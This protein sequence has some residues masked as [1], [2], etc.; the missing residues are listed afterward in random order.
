MEAKNKTQLLEQFSQYLEAVELEPETEQT[1]LYSLFSE[2]AALRNEVKTESRQFKN[3]LG[4]FK[5]GFDS[6]QQSNN[7]LTKE[8][9]NY[10][11]QLETQK[12]QI[13]RNL[14]LEFLE[15]YDRLLAGAKMLDT[16]K[17][18]SS[19]F[20]HS[21]KQDKQ[22]IHSIQEGQNIS[23][24]RLEQLLGKYEVTAIEVLNKSLNPHSMTAIEIDHNPKVDD[25]I[26]TEEL[27]KGF[28]WQDEVLRLA[29][30]KVN[31]QELK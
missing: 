8:L 4:D 26:V 25:G 1:D 14:L 6:L 22:F 5:T 10:R 9:D 27:R 7:E 29:E 12:K 19:L 11:T 3:A 23:L 18:V 2:M 21:Q 31:K 28:K 16:Y 30:V 24:R 17:P 20:G 15:V 13:T